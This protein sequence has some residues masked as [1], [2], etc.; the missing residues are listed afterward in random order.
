M[1]ARIVLV[2]ERAVGGPWPWAEGL[3]CADWFD[4]S[5]RLSCFRRKCAGRGKL[6]GVGLRGYD[7]LNLVPPSPLVGDWDSRLARTYGERLSDWLVG[8]YSR[9]VLLGRRASDA[10]LGYGAEFL[11]EHSVD[12]G[13]VRL[14]TLAHP[15]G[16]S[17]WWND[18]DNWYA[19][20]EAIEE[21]LR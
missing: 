5:V 20:A 6:E 18:R 3:R 12:D 8:R 7:C 2:G 1:A 16:Q 10:A 21:F 13:A 11:T 14:L 19:A 17:R 9:A 4:V 15:S